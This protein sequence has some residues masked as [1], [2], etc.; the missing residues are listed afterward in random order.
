MKKKQINIITYKAGGKEYSSLDEVPEKY[1]KLFEQLRIND[2]DSQIQL[3][4][5]KEKT[6]SSIKELPP[7]LQ[8]KMSDALGPESSGKI[9][10]VVYK[11]KG[12]AKIIG[13]TPKKAARVIYFYINLLSVI[14]GLAL[15][16]LSKIFFLPTINWLLTVIISL[17]IGQI[18]YGIIYRIYRKKETGVK[19][20]PVFL[21]KAREDLYVAQL[22]GGLALLLQ[23]FIY[24]LFFLASR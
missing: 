13:V 15:R 10:K 23:A 21:D 14:E 2:D 6:Y 16:S 22:G 9:D 20:K 19:V 12:K 8:E 7:E 17:I 3:E 24:F 5:S 4:S 18:C 1:R 11:E